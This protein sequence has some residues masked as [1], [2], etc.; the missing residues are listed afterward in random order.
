[1]TLIELI[2]AVLVGVAALLYVVRQALE[3][4]GHAPGAELLRKENADLLRYNEE[5]ERT[6]GRLGTEVEDL[7]RKVAHLEL[8]N[9]AAVL[10]ALEKHEVGA[11]SRHA[12]NQALLKRA[13]AALEGGGS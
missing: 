4:S 1:M 7:R 2:P 3:L 8:T 6:V 5:L 13:V 11:A 9:Q 10:R 12:E